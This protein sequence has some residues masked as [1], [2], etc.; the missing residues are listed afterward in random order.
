[1]T[2][3]PDIERLA[4]LYPALSER[5]SRR[6]LREAKQGS[7]S[8]EEIIIRHSARLL[9]SILGR[10]RCSPSV[11][12]DLYQ[13]GQIE[14]R[15]A[16]SRY[17]PDYGTKWSTY[18]YRSAS[19]KMAGALTEETAFALSSETLKHSTTTVDDD[20]G[21]LYQI[22]N[23]LYIQHHLHALSHRERLVIVHYYGLDPFTRT[24]NELAVDLGI[25]RQR[26]NQIKD[27]AL[28]K[29]HTRMSKEIAA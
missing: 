29:L 27:A 2:T 6:L 13:E 17:D 5:D 24:L 3:S 25:C 16:I 15:R 14:L 1:M 7:A 19:N 12:D 21:E 28:L 18:A 9:R 10:L 11:A 20:D 23:Q 4:L 26:V 8:A 22:C